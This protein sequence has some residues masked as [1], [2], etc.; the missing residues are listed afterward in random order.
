MNIFAY[1]TRM[2]AKIPRQQRTVQFDSTIKQQFSP[3]RQ[4]SELSGLA[5]WPRL[6]DTRI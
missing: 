1:M 2:D 3:I 6:L 5:F 4:H